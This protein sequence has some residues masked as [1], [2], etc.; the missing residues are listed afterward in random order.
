MVGD[1]AMDAGFP[2]DN[3]AAMDSTAVVMMQWRAHTIRVPNVQLVTRP[4]PDHSL[5]SLSRLRH[6]QC[7]ARLVS[8]L[9]SVASAQV[10][11]NSR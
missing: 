2:L 1:S 10:T 6:P 3:V 4:F 9:G 7:T 5:G 8:M 11:R